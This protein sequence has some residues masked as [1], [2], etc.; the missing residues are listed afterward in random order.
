MDIAPGKTKLFGVGGRK[1]V[2]SEEAGGRTVWV[3]KNV[4][5]HLGCV[6]PLTMEAKLTKKAEARIRSVHELWAQESEIPLAVCR[7]Q[8]RAEVLGGLRHQQQVARLPEGIE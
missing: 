6:V 1:G 4:M 3:E 5:Q 7:E 2:E 8:Y